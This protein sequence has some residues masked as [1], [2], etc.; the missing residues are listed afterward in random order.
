MSL[1]LQNIFADI[2]AQLPE[3]LFSSLC[4][5]ASVH[6]ERIVSQ[7]HITP[8][9]QWYDQEWDEWVLVLQGSATLSYQTA[10]AMQM[11][12]GDHVLIPAHTLHRVDCTDPDV[13]TIWLAVHIRPA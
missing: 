5:R 13:K 3:E 4:V 12:T 2:P 9:G 7:G 6:I 11:T 8:S 1:E 10:A